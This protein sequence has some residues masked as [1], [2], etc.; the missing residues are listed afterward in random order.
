[1]ACYGFDIKQDYFHWLC[2]MVHI[3]QEDRS[4]WLLAKD[5]HSRK[6]YSIVS[7]DENRAFDGISLR[8]EYIS[9][10]NYPKYV[11]LNDECSVLEMIIGL[12]RRMDFETSDP[13]D[14]E[15]AE[16]RTTY[17]F[18]EMIENLGLIEFDDESYVEYG[19]VDVVDQTI[20]ILLDREYDSDGNGGLFPLEF[21]DGDQ[22]KVELW[23]QMNSYL[24]EK[25]GI[26][27]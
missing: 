21:A 12:A 25:E 3:E 6:F 14:P 24:M 22:R 19:G 27:V 7:H 10:M 2:E 17:W 4:Y 9:E 8:D 23:Y 18:W 15:E 11:R 5:L 16:S 1:M 26:A 13:Y 20:D